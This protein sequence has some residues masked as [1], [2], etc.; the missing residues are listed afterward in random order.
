MSFLDAVAEPEPVVVEK[1]NL[2]TCGR[3]T[4]EKIAPHRTVNRSA[5]TPA[6]PSRLE[7]T[8][9]KGPREYLGFGSHAM[10][11]Q[12]PSA[13]EVPGPG[14]YGLPKSFLEEFSERDS[15]G[16][17]G[18]GAFASRCARV[19]PRSVPALPRAGRGVPGPGKYEELQ[20]LHAV[21]KTRD[22]NRAPV[23]ASF[24]RPVDKHGASHPVPPAEPQPGPGHYNQGVRADAKEV[25]AARAS[26]K[27]KSSRMGDDKIA[28][29]EFPGPG[30]YHDG[31]VTN[32]PVDS[33]GL[34]AAR[35]QEAYNAV[36]KT[37]S[38]PKIVSVNRDLPT[39][40]YVGR[41]VLGDFADEVGR[42]VKASAGVKAPGPGSYDVS[43]DQGLE[44]RLVGAKGASYFQEGTKRTEWA[45]RE[46]AEK[47][48]PGRYN[49]K[50]DAVCPDR[51][52]DA[53]SAFESTTERG[54]LAHPDAPG[55]CY[56]KPTLPKPT[57]SFRAKN[58]E[59]WA[60]VN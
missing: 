38:R 22:F 23:T 14:S 8:I 20:A 17:R 36:F 33:Q 37:P 42:E 32:F 12:P 58:T 55:P 51:V 60:P 16:K 7:T 24:A 3:Y 6:I 43:R 9:F 30:E 54:K 49:P 10:R 26:F 45:S 1:Q 39:A 28:A 25:N 35:V 40:D 59:V 50:R 21:Q 56:Y 15:W 29:S 53:S 2:R 18:T 46:E 48:G 44:G 52:T 41:R 11:W 5:S 13:N 31:V 57:K 27:S 19:G 34:Q 4:G 47:P